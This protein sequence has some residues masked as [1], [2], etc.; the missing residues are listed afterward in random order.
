MFTTL[1]KLLSGLFALV[2]ARRSPAAPYAK[3][4]G[5]R[6]VIVVGDI[7]MGWPDELR[8]LQVG[9]RCLI[10]GSTPK[11]VIID[12]VEHFG[13]PGCYGATYLTGPKPGSF[14]IALKKHLRFFYPESESG[15]HCQYALPGYEPVRPRF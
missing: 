6:R 13:V 3:E 15:S 4:C 7:H 9:D 1:C 5:G 8:P 14:T 11:V 2:T 12:S 10:D